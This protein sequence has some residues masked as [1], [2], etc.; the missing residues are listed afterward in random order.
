LFSV[1]TTYPHLFNSNCT[2]RSIAACL[3][4]ANIATPPTSS[5]GACTLAVASPEKTKVS[6]KVST[7]RR[8]VHTEELAS[9]NAQ[10]RPLRDLTAQA[11]QRYIAALG[12]SVPDRLYE[13]VMAEVEPAMLTTVLDH[14]QGNQSRA[15]SM[16]GLNRGTLRRK[17]REYGLLS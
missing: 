5:S 7:T 13:L 9:T 1:G 17:L 2:L 16:L 12:G 14:A 10:Q 4:R 3:R 6:E 11:L 15:A 8:R